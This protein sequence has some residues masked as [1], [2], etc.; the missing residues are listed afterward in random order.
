VKATTV[1][2]KR[3]GTQAERISRGET[4]F[5]PVNQVRAHEYVAEQI[6]RHI[7]LHLVGPGEALPSER[8]LV[9]QFGVGRPTIQMALRLLEAEH[10]IEVRRGRNGGTFI[11]APIED[12]DARYELIARIRRRQPEIEE[13]LDFREVIEP[14][15]AGVAANKR[16]QVDLK[17]MRA[18]LR[19]LDAASNEAGYMRYDT[20]L[21]LALAAAT[22]NRF[23]TSSAEEVRRGLNDVISLLPES[24]VWQGRIGDEHH[25]L[26]DAIEQ[27]D[28]AAATEVM[29][30]HVAHTRQGVLAVLAAIKRRGGA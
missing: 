20:E 22:Y 16:R 11:L 15:I 25:R 6:R 8:E 5:D 26:V 1:R 9:R 12:Q 13:L 27:R 14:A 2:T 7:K 4:E 17:K 24:D 30:V 21:H 29:R 18:A 23:L 19:E 3:P 10:L 28:G